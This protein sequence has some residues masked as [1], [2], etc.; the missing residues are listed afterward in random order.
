MQESPMIPP[1][2]LTELRL[3]PLNNIVLFPK[4]H[5]PLHIFEERYKSMIRSCLNEQQPFGVLLIRQGQEV[6]EPSEPFKIGTTARISKIQELQE[7]RL[8]LATE[9]ERRF[10]LIDIKQTLPYMTGL[11]RYFGNDEKTVSNSLMTSIKAEFLLFLSHQAT[12]AGGW[13]S[14]ITLPED[15]DELLAQIISGISSSIDI[16][17]ELRQRLLE[18]NECSERL[19]KLVPILQKGNEIMREQSEKTNPFQ[20][21]RLN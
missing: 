3:F 15:P 20:G 1:D 10:E 19:E 13:N 14:N 8:N 2:D 4:M 17:T 11:I 9:G 21:N 18:T 7:G 5:L 16:P 12:I 6:G